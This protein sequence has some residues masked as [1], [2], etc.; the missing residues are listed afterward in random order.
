MVY[1]RTT[2]W[3][4]NLGLCFCLFVAVFLPMVTLGT[5]IG[6]FAATTPDDLVAMCNFEV[7]NSST[8]FMLKETDK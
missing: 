8:L 7:T 3:A 4:C 5:S 2:H 1:K 6:H